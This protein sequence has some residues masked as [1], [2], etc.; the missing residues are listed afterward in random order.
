MEIKF[1]IY[2]DIIVLYLIRLLEKFIFK[3]GKEV[4]KIVKEFYEKFN[5]KLEKVLLGFVMM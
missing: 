5:V 3:N 2:K 4:V 1:E